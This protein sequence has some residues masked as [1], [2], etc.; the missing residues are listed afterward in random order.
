MSA[1]A[2]T[3]RK[4]QPNCDPRHVE[5]YVRLEHATLGSLPIKTL[6]REAKIAAD[7]INA[8]PLAESESLAVSFG[9]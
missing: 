7:C 2:E 1:Y 5:A 9:L 6:R 4:L 3:F 8:V